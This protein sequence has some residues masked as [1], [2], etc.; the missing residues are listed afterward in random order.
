MFCVLINVGSGASN[1][2]GRGKWFSDGTFEYLPLSEIVKTTERV[3]TYRELGFSQV[4][5]PDI[6]VHLD[7]EFKTFTYGHVKRGFGDI[8]CFKELETGDLL[9][10]YST[11]QYGG[12]WAPF[13]IGYFRIQRVIN[14]REL[15]VDNILSLKSKGFQNNA[16]LKREDPHVDFLVKG[17]N[18]SR[19]LRRAFPLAEH[20][21]PLTLRGLLKELILTPTGKRIENGKPWHRWT[22]VCGNPLELLR[23]IESEQ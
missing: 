3:P 14:C 10:F 13:I 23:I 4:K 1:P 8:K 15:S 17:D 5:F 12:T 6:P 2:N 11:L 18:T 20:T 22:L 19:L 21:K 16:H 9:V 7:P